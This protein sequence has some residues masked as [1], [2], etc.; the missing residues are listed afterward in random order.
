LGTAA[1]SLIQAIE[2]EL[3]EGVEHPSQRAYLLVC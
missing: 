3:Y 1:F 2:R